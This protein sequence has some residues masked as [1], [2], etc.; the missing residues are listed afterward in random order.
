MVTPLLVANFSEQIGGGEI[1]LIEL[2]EELINRGHTPIIAIP[3]EGNLGRELEGKSKVKILPKN[4]SSASLALREIAK[5]CDL[6]HTTGARGLVAA[7]LARTGKPLVW[8]VRVGARDKL[9]PI[10]KMMPDLIIANSRCTADRFSKKENVIVIPNGIKIPS[11]P[12]QTL[13]LNANFKY[14]GVIARMTPEKGHLDLLPAIKKLLSERNDIAFFLAGNNQGSIGDEF[15]RLQKEFDENRILMPGFI[16]NIAEHLNE[17]DLIVI[18]SRIEGFGRVAVEAMLCGTP[19]LT[20]KVGG[21]IEV[22]EGLEDLFLPEEK[23]EWSER[24]SKELDSPSKSKEELFTA[25]TRFSIEKHTDSILSAWS[26][27]IK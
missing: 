19:L 14:I 5:E 12:A 2:S 10:L 17:I 6:I 3:G 1:S 13:N 23:E 22:M 21:L 15:R 18:P 16:S 26:S 27:L 4:I 11:K 8:H 9:D 20:R 24:I 25:G 7:W